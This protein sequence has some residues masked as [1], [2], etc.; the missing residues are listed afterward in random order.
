[1]QHGDRGPPLRIGDESRSGLE[2]HFDSV[3]LCVFLVHYTD[4]RLKWGIATL[5]FYVQ[6]WD[7]Y[8]TK[9]LTL[10]L[11]SGPVEGIL[12]LCIVYAVTAIKG[13][14]SYWQQSMLQNFGIAKHSFIPDYIYNLP[15]TEWYMV[16]G[17]IVLVSNTLQR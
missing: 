14:G 15:F 13:G 2:H 7:E 6:T 4:R 17:G 1:M 11:V 12:T 5:T 8:Y 10:G 16:Y 3:W 9:T